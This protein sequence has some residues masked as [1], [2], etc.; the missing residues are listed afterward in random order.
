[1]AIDRTPQIS[2]IAVIQKPVTQLT[3]QKSLA[4]LGLFPLAAGKEL[5][6]LVVDDDPKA[7]DLIAIRVDSIGGS[8]RRAYGG[9]TAIEMARDKIPDLVM[10][11]L[12]MPGVSGLDVV[13]ALRSDRATERIPI[14]FATAMRVTAADRAMFQTYARTISGKAPVDVERR[15][16]EVRSAISARY[17]PPG[18]ASS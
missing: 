18:E 3:L 7:V 17:E 5:D 15:K 1:M 13:E 6:V 16:L 11:D 8:V 10:L 4:E 14:I 2:A 12:L 9:R